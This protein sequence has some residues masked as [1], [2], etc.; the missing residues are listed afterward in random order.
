MSDSTLTLSRRAAIAGGTALMLGGFARP[1]FAQDAA[2]PSGASD[3]VQL[4]NEA[5]E[6]MTKL[7]SFAFELVT[8][9]GETTIFEGLTLEEV[10]GAVRRPND[11]QTTVVVKIPF[12]SLDLRAVSVNGEVWIELPQL[13]DTGGG[14]T[15]LGS[16][17]GVLSLLN[18]DVLILQS[19]RYIDN[20]ELAG[21]DEV[22]G[23]DIT[24]VTGTVDF[25][26][27]AIRLGG[28][29]QEL[30]NQI[31]EGPVTVSVA[32]D[33][34]RLVRKIEIEGPILATESDDVVREVTFSN[35]N[36]PVEIERP[37]V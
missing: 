9:Q 27:I 10:H 1:A 12:A 14:W 28:D 31:A 26:G 22:D 35:F 19:V 3:A 4:L 20:A 18:P 37:N 15:S 29:Q 16:S 34:D 2:T 30:A 25:H 36:E 24:W 11:F 8:T 33:G 5:A 7:E 21:T 17:E 23:V 6:A 13:G 32:I